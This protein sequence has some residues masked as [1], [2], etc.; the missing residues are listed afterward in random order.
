[1]K[2]SAIQAPKIIKTMF[3]ATPLMFAAPLVAAVS[4]PLNVDTFE[5]TTQKEK[6]IFVHNENSL[7][8]C[9]KVGD[10]EV[11]PA[12][13]VDK[14]ENKLYF[15]DLDGYLDSEF[16][17][18]LCKPS[19]PTDAGLRIITS[20]EDYPYEKAPAKTK[21]H[22]SPDEY[23]PKVICLG[24]VDPET[25]E[26]TG[27]NGEFIHGTDKPESIGKNQSKGCV[28]LNNADVENLAEWLSVGQYVLIR[29]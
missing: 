9:I 13:V 19:T 25:G 10:G 1:M 17:V 18:G 21:R 28:R 14:S 8:P 7:S 23:G 2:I 20:I 24:I 29:E 5:K 11:Y 4:N 16:S 12:V 15:Y 22:R 6:S 26:I 27:Y 3:V